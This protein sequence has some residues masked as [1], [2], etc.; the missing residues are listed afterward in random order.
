[1]LNRL[2]VQGTS[3]ENPNTDDI[4]ID[5]DDFDLNGRGVVNWNPVFRVNDD[6][7]LYCGDQVKV[8]WHQINSAYGANQQDL[9]IPIDNEVIQ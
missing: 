3:L 5:E 8:Q 4:F 2:T 9:V 1:P 7:N 6:L